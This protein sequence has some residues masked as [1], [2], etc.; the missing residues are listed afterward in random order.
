MSKNTFL[1][2]F[3]ACFCLLMGLQTKA[4]TAETVWV[5]L[6][7]NYI[8][9]EYEVLKNDP[10]IKQGSYK[11]SQ[12]VRKK[13]GNVASTYLK[14]EG[15]YNQ[16]KQVG[17]WTYFFYSGNTHVDST[18]TFENGLKNGNWTTY[19]S[20]S[21]KIKSSGNYTNDLR[22]GKWQF[23]NTDGTPNYESTYNNGY[24]DGEC[25]FYKDNSTLDFTRLYKDNQL[26]ID[27]T[28][29]PSQGINYNLKEVDTP[30]TF[31]GGEIAIFRY[32][33]ETI[34]YPAVARE[35][36]IQGAVYLDFI[37]DENG[38]IQNIVVAQPI[39][40]GCNEEA[41]RVIKQ[42]PRWIPGRLDGKPVRVKYTLPIK[43]KLQ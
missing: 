41:L 29:M 33:A 37:I 32:L 43:F 9:Y 2:L 14:T 1:L 5:T 15:L 40:G 17:T 13:N 8:R 16:N 19:W 31:I 39:G 22:T 28:T 25:L 4:Q 38:F 18:G 27:T 21:Y 35:N 6:D 3:S 23:Y 20:S 24:L 26:V 11:E 42:M 7:T 10:S 36:G 34:R 30:P 12:I